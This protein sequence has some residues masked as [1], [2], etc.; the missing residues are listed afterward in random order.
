M[1]D[2]LTRKS[3]T[4][5]AAPH[6]TGTVALLFEA[7]APRRLPM[8]VTRWLVMESAR[9][10]ERADPR[11]GAGLLD[12]AAACRLAASVVRRP[13]LVQSKALFTSRAT[14]CSPYRSP[15]RAGRC[16]ARAK[17]IKPRSAA[18][19]GGPDS[20]PSARMLPDLPECSSTLDDSAFGDRCNGVTHMMM[21]GGK[22]NAARNIVAEPLALVA[23]TVQ[24]SHAQPSAGVGKVGNGNVPCHPV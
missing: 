21:L 23:E 15:I 3:G 6:V 8:A 11:Y 16:T 24:G 12:T 20:C 7:V 2:G 4:S 14:S 9:P 17:T 19:L 13:A 1:R 5:M 18:A 10:P 22:S